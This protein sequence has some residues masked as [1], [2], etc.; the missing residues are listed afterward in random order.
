M[1]SNLAIYMRFTYLVAFGVT[2]GAIAPTRSSQFFLFQRRLGWLLRAEI[3]APVCSA[4]YFVINNVKCAH[5]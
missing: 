2:R 4:R 3:R 1:E 5:L